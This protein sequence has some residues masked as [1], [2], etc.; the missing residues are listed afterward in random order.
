[1][2]KALVLGFVFFII[3]GQ[4]SLFAD[5]KAV[6]DFMTSYEALVVEAETLAK[7][8]AITAMDMMP[9][10]MKALDFAEK[11]E[12]IQKDTSWNMNDLMKYMDLSTRYAKAADDIQKKILLNF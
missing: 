9:L 12:V 10:T 8:A 11:A 1:M 2:K 6:D 3:I 5:R 7:K 4:G